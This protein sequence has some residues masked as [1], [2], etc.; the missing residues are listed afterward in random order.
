M[1]YKLKNII[2]FISNQ[3]VWTDAQLWLASFV[4]EATLLSPRT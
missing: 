4:D 1:V 2:N 3:T